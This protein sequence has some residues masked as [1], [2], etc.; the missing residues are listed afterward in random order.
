[1]DWR[2]GGTGDDG[3]F[4]LADVGAGGDFILADVGDVTFPDNQ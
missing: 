1:M 3:D 2:H 4:I